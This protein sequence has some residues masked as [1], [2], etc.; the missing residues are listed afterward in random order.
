MSNGEMAIVIV[1]ALAVALAVAIGLL[2]PWVALFVL[3]RPMRRLRTLTLLASTFAIV[4]LLGWS[5]SESLSNYGS[6]GVLHLILAIVAFI[7]D[8]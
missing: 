6:G 7:R 5:A 3:R 2:L 4:V 1:T 8:S